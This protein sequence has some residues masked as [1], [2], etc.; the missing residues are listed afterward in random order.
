M[1]EKVIEEIGH[2]GNKS[3]ET[4]S[5]LE[6]IILADNEARVKALEIIGLGF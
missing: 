4:M 1:I 5:G 2:S 3:L 6:E